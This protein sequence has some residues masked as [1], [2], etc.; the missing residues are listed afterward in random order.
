MT[1]PRYASHEE[2]HLSIEAWCNEASTLFAQVI[3][4]LEILEQRLG[5]LD[6]RVSEWERGP[7]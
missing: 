6:A 4:R 5:D 7:R 3:E 2:V 1:E